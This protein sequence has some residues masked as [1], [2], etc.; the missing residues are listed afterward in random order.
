MVRILNPQIISAE[1]SCHTGNYY[2]SVIFI[3]LRVCCNI[4]S[5]HINTVV[6]ENDQSVTRT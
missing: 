3:N 4:I 5:S 2:F 6:T 1:A